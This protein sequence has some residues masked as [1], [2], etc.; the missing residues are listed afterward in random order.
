MSLLT[1]I[2]GTIGKA[3]LP[4]VGKERDKLKAIDSL[5]TK[6]GEVSKI[7]VMY[8]LSIKLFNLMIYAYL[9]WAIVNNKVSLMESLKLLIQ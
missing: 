3:I 2:L 1:S 9:V 8:A 4:S 5:I 7:E 6:R